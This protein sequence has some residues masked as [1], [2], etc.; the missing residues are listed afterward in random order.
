[1][2]A[3]ICQRIDIPESEDTFFSCF[4]ISLLECRVEGMTGFCLDCVCRDAISIH[5]KREESGSL[6]SGYLWLWDFA[7]CQ[8]RNG[9]SSREPGASDDQQE[10]SDSSDSEL[11]VE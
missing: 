1:M 9:A 11:L 4:F 7:D 8:E 3:L 5:P 2:H 10:A 6:S